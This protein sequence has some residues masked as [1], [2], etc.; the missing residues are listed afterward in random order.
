MRTSRITR[1]SHYRYYP[2]M[3]IHTVSGALWLSRLA[4]LPSLLWNILLRSSRTLR[5]DT[6][7]PVPPE[8]IQTSEDVRPPEDV[9]PP[10][11]TQTK[12]TTIHKPVPTTISKKR[13]FICCDGTGRDSI[14]QRNDYVT[15]VARFARCI[16]NTAEDGTRQLVYYREGVAMHLGDLHFREAATGQGMYKLTSARTRLIRFQVSTA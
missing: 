13:L 2:I 6:P 15:N 10:E 4:Y 7:Q 1:F 12:N 5:G 8:N 9:Q 11:D 3:P 14:R 16:K